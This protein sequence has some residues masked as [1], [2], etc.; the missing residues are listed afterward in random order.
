VIASVRPLRS[1]IN[2]TRYSASASLTAPKHFKIAFSH[3]SARLRALP[4]HFAVSYGRRSDGSTTRTYPRSGSTRSSRLILLR[5]RQ[6]SPITAASGHSGFTP[7]HHAS[8]GASFSSLR[9]APAPA[10]FPS[11]AAT[12]SADFRSSS[13]APPAT[14][15]AFIGIFNPPQ[16]RRRRLRRLRILSLLGF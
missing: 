15:G 2:G 8:P 1:S 14:R 11:E 3:S 13:K 6:Q 5:D 7:S 9:S 12:A 16:H 10:H 4:K